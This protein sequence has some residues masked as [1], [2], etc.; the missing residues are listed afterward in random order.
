[1]L[2]RRS[3]GQADGD[4]QC[5]NTTKDW[6]GNSHERRSRLLLRSIRSCPMGHRLCYRIIILGL[7]QTINQR[8]RVSFP[9]LRSPIACARRRP[10]QVNSMRR[11]LVVRIRASSPIGQRFRQQSVS[12][13]IIPPPC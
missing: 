4:H 3:I 11:S 6:R 5:S 2:R 12:R 8:Q 9:V 10:A 1:V 13:S 7:S